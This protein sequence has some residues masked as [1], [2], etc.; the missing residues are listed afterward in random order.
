MMARDV[1]LH[2]YPELGFTD[3]HHPL[4]HHANN[5]DKVAKFASINTYEMSMFAK[6]LERLRSTSD[7]DGSLLDHSAVLYGSGMSDG[8]LHS[9]TGLP[10]IV[11]GGRAAQI[12][13]GRHLKNPVVAGTGIP[14]GNVLLTL[15]QKFGLELNQFGQSSGTIDL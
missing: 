8:N 11:A 14:N 3:G 12:N 2:N 5:P 6:F 1:S 4:S 15:G 10:V 9:H 13:G 7:G